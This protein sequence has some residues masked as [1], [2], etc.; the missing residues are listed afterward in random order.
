MEDILEKLT[1]CSQKLL[2]F[3]FWKISDTLRNALLS[4]PILLNR[5][6]IF[7]TRKY[8]TLMI[9]ITDSSHSMTATCLLKRDKITENDR[10]KWPKYREKLK[11]AM[12]QTKEHSLCWLC[13]E[14]ILMSHLCSSVHAAT[15]VNQY[16]KKAE[17][18]AIMLALSAFARLTWNSSKNMWVDNSPL[19]GVSRLFVLVN[20]NLHVCYC[21]IKKIRFSENKHF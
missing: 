7:M 16:L 11:S 13:G 14:S 20:I 10:E 1:Q 8:K 21:C 12:Q 2:E 17:D 19:G 15:C 6:S 3:V 5:K 18:K 9:S 4:K